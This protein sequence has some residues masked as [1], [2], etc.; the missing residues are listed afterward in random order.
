MGDISSSATP[1]FSDRGDSPLASALA[2]QGRRWRAGTPA[3]VEE[4]LER[5]PELRA[6]PE[7]ILD[8]IYN[9]VLLRT[10]RGET[11]R[12][13]EYTGRFPALAD[14][15]GPIFEVHQAVES[16]RDLA[17]S[18]SE[19]EPTHLAA[20][21]GA[22][23][24]APAVPEIPGYEI[25]ERLGHGGMGVVYRALQKSLGRTVALKMVLSG[26]HAR[27][28]EL[29]RFR[30]E[31]EAMARLPHPNIV[32]IHE[33][34][35]QDG[36]P[37][38]SLEF[39]EGGG[40]DK[41][42]GGTPQAAGEAARL[43]E[44]LARAAHH[45]HA[46]GVVHRDLKPA[47]VLLT[48][49]GTPKITD[50]GLARF[51]AGSGQTQSGDILGTPSYM[52][53]EQAAGHV[54]TLGPAA[55]VYALGAILYELLTGRPPFRAENM[56]E[57]LRQVVE[58][59]AVPVRRLQ[60][61]VPSDLETICLKCLQKLPRKRYAAA[62][63]LADD[64][65]RFQEGRPILARPTP[66]W[67]RAIKWA[68]RRPALA[69]LYALAAAAA[70]VLSLYT[71]WLRDALTETENQR[72]A[73]QRAQ[74]QAEAAA[75]ERRLQLVRARLADG[76]RLLE[77]GDWFGALLPFAEALQLDQHDPKRAEIHRIR[78]AAILR[79][80]PRLVQFWPHDSDMRHA[81]ITAD[82]RRV[83]T[84]AGNAARLWDVGTGA[85]AVPPMIHGKLITAAALSSDGLRVA[86]SADDQTVQVWD[87][88]T[89]QRL[90]PPLS[91]KDPVVRIAFSG[92]GDRVVAA[93]RGATYE[94][95][96][97]ALEV[98]TGK[99][100]SPPLTTQTAP[101]S[102]VALSPDGRLA[103]TA[104]LV[105]TKAGSHAV[106]TVWDVAFA[107]RLFDVRDVAGAITQVH[108]SPD[109][110]RVAAASA[111]GTAHVWDC[112]TGKETAH[113][114]QGAPLLHL[115]FSA[116]G[117]RLATAGLDGV[118]RVWDTA[119][120]KDLAT[121]RHGQAFTHAVTHVAFSPDGLYAVTAGADNTARVWDA[122]TGNATA[123]PLRHGDKVIRA[124]FSPQGRLVL[125]ASADRA[126]R[127]WDLASGRLATPP[128]EHDDA[129]SHAAF[130]QSGRRAVTA[131]DDRVACV[132]DLASGRR[133]GPRLVHAHQVVYAAFAA[134]GR[135]VTTGE[136]N[137]G[138]V[139]EA[140]VW[141]AVAGK[142]LSRRTTAQRIM[143]VPDTDRTVRRAWFSPDGRW[144]LAVDRA[145][146]AQVWDVAAGQSATDILEHAS[147]VTGVSFSADG[148]HV[149]TETFLPSFTLRALVASGESPDAL[150]RLI[151][152]LRPA[153]TI[154]V[155]E[156]PGGKRVA[157]VGPWSDAASISFRHASFSPEALLLV[158]DGEARLWDVAEGRIVRRFR[159]SGA[160]VDRAALSPD[161][162][163]LATASDDETAQLWNA[164]SGELVPTPVQFRHGGQ[165][166]PPLFSMDGR[167]LVLS[168]RP[169]G[170][171]IWDAATGDPVSPPLGHPGPV[172][173]VAFSSD[174]RFLLTASDRAA[175]VWPLTGDDRTTDN[176]LRL[177]QLLS[178]SRTHPQGGR[179]VPLGSDD[180]RMAWDELRRESPSDFTTPPRDVITWHA[181]AARVCE[182]TGQWDAAL[183]HLDRLATLDP[184]RLD[185][186]A[187]KGR[188]RAELGQ[189][190]RAAADFEK[191]TALVAD[192]PRFW[193]RHALVRLHL[194]DRDGYRRVCADMLTRFGSSK[195]LVAAQL[196]AW[197]GSLALDT[198]ADGAR[199]VA[200][201]ER[202]VTDSPRNHAR[203][204]TLGAAL[205]RA[206]RYK[207]AVRKL[208]EAVKVWGK[209]DTPWDWLFLAMAHH[210]LGQVELAKAHFDRAAR[211]LDQR[212][213]KGAAG[214]PAPALFWSDR[215]ELS[216]LRREAEAVMTQA[217][218]KKDLDLKP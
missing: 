190:N 181:E 218:A 124:S 102:Q 48:A 173:S 51:G 182:K 37:F 30:R 184:E 104:D 28:E 195:D 45:A 113:V 187:R 72:G 50:F 159:K 62:A 20:G 17:P 80:C 18:V 54:S 8:L 29:M 123:P 99:P 142:L 126:V 90:G 44:T 198:E 120:G 143:G 84:A 106:L 197:T 196:A 191:A 152:L 36:R 43:V 14:A 6:N 107:K 63:D 199:L 1:T 70:V 61:K 69:G 188:A 129:V 139:G 53:P 185:L 11:P 112:A 74:N 147:A 81:E 216:L 33:V 25:L 202:A 158:S 168:S 207:E 172:E 98:P 210:R 88:A 149:L 117:R 12:L 67:E 31:A 150:S 140:C 55:D 204:L 206:R 19:G 118:A 101:L 96:I 141:D 94:I 175:R 209:D 95:R 203:L 75:E 59:E 16:G 91:F 215:L 192:R 105:T 79:Q 4:C 154:T 205:Y 189:W 171:R 15:L 165:S 155:W 217:P 134:D 211:W 77:D 97:Q 169:A 193:Y 65:R 135:V 180:L 24:P 93:T 57:T 47:N 38:L 161:G 137:Q 201:A 132:W 177:G 213:G 7:A 156:V 194:D 85:E 166:W 83:L 78:L 122:A 145:G 212:L 176:W 115:A 64:L 73:A 214:T 34:G 71:I 5:Y 183:S 151:G 26:A 60:P 41:K 157:S 66:A 100:A 2:E 3:A 92:G 110:G 108:F 160:G 103:A 39:V 10:E 186:F 208:D 82:G 23:E 163:T 146:A 58:Q 86:T 130:D 167:F 40:L 138:G 153:N 76:S 170:V 32:Q 109:S 178:C 89:S 127:V 13:D 174:G 128:L 21:S 125:T 121:L 164:A 133:Q 116:D 119:T 144:L 42:L 56:I 87:A 179:P 52:A 49:D 131:G 162:R 46:Q 148:R 68:R 136:H 9:E 27:P 200:A 111:D 35:E 114:R 22:S